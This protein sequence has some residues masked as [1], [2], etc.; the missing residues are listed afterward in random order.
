MKIKHERSSTSYQAIQA[1]VV[2]GRR[3]VS[4]VRRNSQQA[5]ALGGGN[6]LEKLNMLE[7]GLNVLGG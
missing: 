6:C 2:G 3:D 5:V 1:L 7:D 4:Y